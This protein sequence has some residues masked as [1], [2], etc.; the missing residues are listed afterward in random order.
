MTRAQDQEKAGRID[1]ALASVEVLT[2]LAPENPLALDRLAA[3]H[4][5]LGQKDQALAVL[6]RWQTHH[7]HDPVPMMRQAVFLYKGGQTAEGQ[8]KVAQALQQGHGRQKA[9]FAL[10][11]ARLGTASGSHCRCGWYDHLC[12]RSAE[13]RGR[14]PGRRD[15]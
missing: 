6:A 5:R 4:H 2:R 9:D 14:L 13:E 15:P 11:G 1:L 8:D 12:G 7:P 3:L 10:W